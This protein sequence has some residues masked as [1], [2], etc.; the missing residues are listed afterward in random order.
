MFD[1]SF[2][3]EADLEFV[4]LSDTHYMLDPGRQQVEFESRRRQTARAEWAL[5]LSASLTPAFVV[6]LGDLVQEFPETAGF[7]RAMNEAREQ[8]ARCGVQPRLV[9]GN[10]DVGDKPD[11]TMPTAW[12]TAESLAAYHALSGRSWYSWDAGAAHCV[13]LNSQLLNAALPEAQ[14]QKQ[15]LEA[16]L[17]AHK[18]GRIFVF[19]HLAPFLK[20]E[21]EPSLGHYDNI[22]EPARG[23]LLN[24]LRQ[25]TVEIIFSAHS[26]FAF[27]N[28]IGPTRHFGTASSLAARPAASFQPLTNGHLRRRSSPGSRE[29][30]RTRRWA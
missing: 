27:F 21:Q 28:R 26:H 15:W 11:P 2:L 1:R 29:T 20:D 12:V 3:P 24:L 19:L 16:D 8:L 9:A 14:A 4:I 18:G 10:H 5:R 25:H 30:Y 17:R 6:H 7:E 23:W 22:A 13:V